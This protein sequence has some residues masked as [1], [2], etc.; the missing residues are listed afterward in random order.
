M[1]YQEKLLDPKWLAKRQRILKRDSYKCT[2]CGSDEELRVHHTF[3]YRVPT[4]PWDY[5]NKSLITLCEKCHYEYH[6]HNENTYKNKPVRRIKNQKAKAKRKKPLTRLERMTRKHWRVETTSHTG[7]SLAIR[8]FYA[9]N[10]QG[11]IDHMRRLK[12]PIFSIR[13]IK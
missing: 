7:K 9:K 6:V 5:P 13:E 1:T 8:C 2:A 10:R 11:A 12:L 4:D 3:Y